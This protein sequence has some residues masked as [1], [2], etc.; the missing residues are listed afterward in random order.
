MPFFLS[1]E[2]GFDKCFQVWISLTV[3]LDSETLT[4]LVLER[5]LSNT[6]WVLISFFKIQLKGGEQRER[7]IFLLVIESQMLSAAKDKPD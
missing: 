3:P 5:L 2:S 7:E 6:F 1:T 4:Q